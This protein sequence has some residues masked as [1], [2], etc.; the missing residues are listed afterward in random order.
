MGVQT[1]TSK[2]KNQI[3]T[4]ENADKEVCIQFIKKTHMPQGTKAYQM[5]IKNRMFLYMNGYVFLLIY[6][7]LP[8]MSISVTYVNPGKHNSNVIIMFCT[9]ISSLKNNSVSKSPVT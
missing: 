1:N 9:C 6:V 3:P 8:L 5:D 7:H 2:Q 4:D